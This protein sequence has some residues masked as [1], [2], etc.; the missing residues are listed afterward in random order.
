MH[1]DSTFPRFCQHLPFFFFLV[2]ILT[3]ILIYNCCVLSTQ[4]ERDELCRERV[5]GE[6]WEREAKEVMTQPRSE[7]QAS[8]SDVAVGDQGIQEARGAGAPALWQHKEG[9]P[10]SEGRPAQVGE[11]EGRTEEEQAQGFTGQRSLE[12]SLELHPKGN[13]KPGDQVHYSSSVKDD[14]GYSRTMGPE[15]VDARK[16]IS[17]LLQQSGRERPQHQL[18]GWDQN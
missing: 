15:S 4:E 6:T 11:E 14:V 18:T 12:N 7:N 17:R 16:L 8:P 1:E 9:M 13:R 2:A 10:G 3:T 5:L